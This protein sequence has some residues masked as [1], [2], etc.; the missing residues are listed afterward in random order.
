MRKSLSLFAVLLFGLW[1][2]TG[3]SEIKVD[4]GL[5]FGQSLNLI[6]G[7]DLND[8]NNNPVATRGDTTGRR[9][10]GSSERVDWFN[11]LLALNGDASVK[12]YGGGNAGLHFRIASHFDWLGAQTAGPNTNSTPSGGGAV[13][14][15]RVDGTNPLGFSINQLY[16]KFE[17]FASLPFDATIGRQDIKLGRG[18]VLGNRVIG[19][20][21]TFYAAGIGPS[22]SQRTATGGGITRG[23]GQI[24][25]ANAGNLPISSSTPGV[26]HSP[27]GDYTGFDAVKLDFKWKEFYAN[28]GYI[29]VASAFT[30]SATGATGAAVHQQRDVGGNDEEA[31][32]F[33]NF[34]LN[35][36]LFKK[37][38]NLEFYFLGNRDKEPITNKSVGGAAHSSWDDQIYTWGLRGDMDFAKLWG[39]KNVM[40]FAELDTQNG[41][42]G[43]HQTDGVA[44]RNRNAWAGNAGFHANLDQK[45]SPHFG[46]EYVH[47][48]GPENGSIET[49]NATPDI[50]VDREWTAWDPQFRSLTHTLIMDWLDLF[51]LTDKVGPDGDV[52]IAGQIDSPITNRRMVVVSAGCKP[53][54]KL[55]AT[56]RWAW[57]RLNESVSNSGRTEVFDLGWEIDGLFKYEFSK[58]IDWNLNFG[59]FKPGGYYVMPDAGDKMDAFT[60]QTGFKFSI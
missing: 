57:A 20:G 23:N 4:W 17:D 15:Y 30:Q 53:T 31:L 42:L 22:G 32:A 21:P 25:S 9:G 26:Y 43:T 1:V 44:G 8:D 47:Y 51:Y 29:L 34:G 11:T 54:Q 18:F 40:V 46:I 50:P 49:D 45:R 3:Y 6:R 37:P 7:F 48:S 41:T 56:L 27:D 55:D 60:V 12:G 52:A 13:N 59:W 14:A 5:D 28:L 58:D 39:A 24:N 10:V 33:M 38:S 2:S 35:T 19:A 16:V 36:K